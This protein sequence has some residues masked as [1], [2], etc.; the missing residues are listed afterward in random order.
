MK[1]IRRVLSK[2]KLR[3]CFMKESVV[4]HVECC[5][6]VKEKDRKMITRFGDTSGLI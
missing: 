3:E 2:S 6:K 1:K 4:K 5:K